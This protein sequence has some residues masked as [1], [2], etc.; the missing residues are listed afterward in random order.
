MDSL[1]REVERLSPTP[2]DP[3]AFYDALLDVLAGHGL[4]FVGACW[5]LTDPA[6]GMW[7]WAGW[8]GE[9]PSGFER[10]LENE[11]L[12]ED[13]GKYADIAT[14]RDPVFALVRGT[15]GRPEASPRF[16][17]QIAPDGFEDELRVAFVDGFGRW[18]SIGLFND[19][20]YGEDDVAAIAGLVPLVARTLREA[21]A[22]AAPQSENAAPGVL[23]L[24]RDDGVRTRDERAGELLA[25]DAETG[26]LPGAIHVLAVRARLT[27]SP[28]Q[29][30]TLGADAGWL[31]VDASP[32]VDDDGAVAIVLRPA[33]PPSLLETRRA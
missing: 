31:A 4:G 16:R 7:T 5:H 21:I 28:V 8:R 13:V 18:G 17:D 2:E 26:S 24:D 1:R 29:G 15:D 19:E 25:G 9:L 20:P 30:R 11:F 10:A 3:D 22:L 33:P 14:W 32:L 23:V 12:E 6:S 27:G